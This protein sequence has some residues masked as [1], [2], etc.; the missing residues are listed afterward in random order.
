[1]IVLCIQVLLSDLTSPKSWKTSSNNILEPLKYQHDDIYQ[2]ESGQV[3]GKLIIDL[4][5]G[6]FE[7]IDVLQV[8]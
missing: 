3:V 7:R 2:S 4:Y 5:L 1:M 6:G 8:S